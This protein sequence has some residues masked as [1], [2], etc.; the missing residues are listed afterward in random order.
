ME[1]YQQQVSPDATQATAPEELHP[2]AAAFG[3]DI[4]AALEKG[5]TEIADRI[6]ALS[7]HMARMNFYRG[8]AQKVDLENNYKEALHTQIHGDPANPNATVTYTPDAS[9][10]ATLSPG[11]APSNTAPVDNP[12]ERPLGVLNWKGNMANGALDYLDQWHNQQQSQMA[13]QVKAMGLRNVAT[14]KNG[15]DNAWTSQRDAVADHEMTQINQAQIAT[16]MKGMQLDSENAITAQTPITLGKVLDSI[17]K[18]NDMLQSSQYGTDNSDPRKEIMGEITLNKMHGEAINNAMTANLK[19][20]GGDPT[21]FQSTLDQLH[22]SGKINDTVYENAGEHLDKMAKGITAQNEMA[23]RTQ[24]VN[25]RMVTMQSAL[26]GKLDLSNPNTVSEI[27]ANDPELGTALSN[28]NLNKNSNIKDEDEAFADATDKVFGAGSKEQISKYMTNVMKEGK[29]SQDRLN[30]LFGAAMDRGKSLADLDN[31]SKSGNPVQNL[32]DQGMKVLFQ[33]NAN[34]EHPNAQ[35]LVDY[36][37][38]IKDGKPVPEA[39]TEAQGQE[40]VRQN[41]HLLNIPVNG[42]IFHDKYGNRRIVY[43]DLHTEAIGGKTATATTEE[44]SDNSDD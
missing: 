23:V 29:I 37:K 20:T 5:G 3:G 40:A 11:Q 16:Y 9:T 35:T 8:E 10:G 42:Q 33:T 24:A 43:P 27:S 44:S 31:Q 2:V 15:I 14:L 6:Q 21:Q 17:S 12:I 36:M 30:I 34:E 25:Q 28:Y 38:S 39:L 13:L 26:N 7:T 22:D 1:Q 18:Q 41:P 4:G 19:S 32:I